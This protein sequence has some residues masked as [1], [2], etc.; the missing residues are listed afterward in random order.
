MSHKFSFFNVHSQKEPLNIQDC[1][2]SWL[3]PQRRAVPCRVASRRVASHHETGS[4]LIKIVAWRNLGAVQSTDT[5]FLLHESAGGRDLALRARR[6]HASELHPLRDGT[7]QP[8]RVEQS[9][10]VSGRERCGR[11]PVYCQQ[12]FLVHHRYLP[13]TGQRAQP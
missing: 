9:A 11:E 6:L 4:V 13:Q 5:A 12:Q 3:D 1:H 7:L 8:V 10:S 2:K